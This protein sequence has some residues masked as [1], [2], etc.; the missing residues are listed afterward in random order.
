MLDAL[1]EIRL[2]VDGKTSQEMLDDHPSYYGLLYLLAVI[3][4]AAGNL[5]A[6]FKEQNKDI[7]WQKIKDMR[8]VVIHEYYGVD[9]GVVWKTVEERIPDLEA[10]IKKRLQDTE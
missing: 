4:E 1:G 10:F 6:D 2:L 3:G 8:N 9:F 5:S 7:P